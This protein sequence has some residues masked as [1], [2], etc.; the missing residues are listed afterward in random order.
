MSSKVD[1]Q[2]LGLLEKALCGP[3][4]RAALQVHTIAL[5]L[6]NSLS[7]T[8]L[9]ARAF[10]WRAKAN[11]SRLSATHGDLP[12]HASFDALEQMAIKNLL[13]SKHE[14]SQAI[15]IYEKINIPQHDLG[16]L[17]NDIAKLLLAARDYDVGSAITAWP[18]LNGFVNRY[19]P[20]A[21]QGEECLAVGLLKASMQFL[22]P[23]QIGY[24]AKALGHYYKKAGDLPKAQLFY[25][26]AYDAYLLSGQYDLADKAMEEL[27][28]LPK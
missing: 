11:A 26:K 12:L 27:L 4:P 13:R 16:L 28:K 25:Q 22:P 15:V 23:D 2:R 8:D 6:I 14:F 5:S 3:D 17:L 9:P 24:A 21:N 10:T 1:P 20:D 18:E 19:L 7:N